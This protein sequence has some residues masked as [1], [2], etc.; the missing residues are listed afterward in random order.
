MQ[1]ERA[2]RPPS[3][4]KARMSTARRAS[5]VYRSSCSG[6]GGSGRPARPRS[7]NLSARSDCRLCV[8]PRES[9]FSSWRGPLG[10]ELRDFSVSACDELAF[11][12]GFVRISGTKVNGEHA[13][14]WARQTLGLR[15]I[16]GAR[17]ITH[18]HT[19]VPFYMNGSFKAAV[20]LAP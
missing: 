12:H 7:K 3:P 1:P 10:Y 4:C 16:D 19:S 6:G 15:K 20:D 17:K 8:R 5:E 11:C 18:E 2:R 14:V 9:W 13:D